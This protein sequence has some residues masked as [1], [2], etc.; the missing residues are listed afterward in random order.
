VPERERA[1]IRQRNGLLKDSWL[2]PRTNSSD[3]NSRC[4]GACGWVVDG[5]RKFSQSVTS[6]PNT[7][8]EENRR[9]SPQERQARYQRILGQRVPA[10]FKYG[11]KRITDIMAK[12]ISIAALREQP[13]QDKKNLYAQ[14]HESYVALQN[15]LG[16]LDIMREG[17]PVKFETATVKKTGNVKATWRRVPARKKAAAQARRSRRSS[18]A[19]G[20]RRCGVLLSG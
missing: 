19:G 3:E 16:V 4:C 10:G 9:P 15:L 13:L 11:H 5:I 2:Q 20:H 14:W 18:R 12:S 7:Q 1:R 17:F 8:A 6:D